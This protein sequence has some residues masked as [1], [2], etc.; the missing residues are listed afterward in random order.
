MKYSLVASLDLRSYNQLIQL[1]KNQY[2]NMFHIHKLT[3][4][5]H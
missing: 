3:N 2:N 5:I 1:L 4:L